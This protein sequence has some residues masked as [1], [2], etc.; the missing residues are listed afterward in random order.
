MKRRLIVH[1]P[2]ILMEQTF[3]TDDIQVLSY[4]EN[5]QNKTS[6]LSDFGDQDE[7]P[8]L[9]E[10][11]IHQQ[12]RTEDNVFQHVSDVGPLNSSSELQLASSSVYG[13]V[14][15]TAD[16]CLEHGISDPI[17]ILRYYQQKIVL[18]RKLDIED[19]SEV[20]EGETNFIL[21]D[22]NR[23]LESALE[24]IS[25]ITN[26]RTC[27]EV[28]F[29]GETSVDLGGPRKEFFVLAL[30]DMK[31]KYFNPVREWSVEYETLGKIMALS[32]LQNGKMPRVL[33]PELIQEIFQKE[34]CRP[35]MKDLRKGL[36]ALG[37]YSLALKLPGLI[38][39]FTPGSSTP[40]TVKKLSHL[41]HPN[42]SE[43]GSNR[44]KIESVVYSNFVKY[45]RE[46]ASGRR[47]NITLQSILQF[48]T[49]SDEEP[50]LGFAL[51]PSITFVINNNSFLPTAN[52]CI[53]KLNLYI[54]E[55]SEDIPSNDILFALYDYA[56][57]N[58]YFG[59]K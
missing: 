18:G 16:Y 12:A 24:E 43:E 54:A 19:D 17:E 50:I 28:Q 56:F 37:V 2:P 49:G 45:M 6:A 23:V 10:T 57:T 9:L 30:R 7:L 20:I 58:S 15:E 32:I 47:G 21:I 4:E 35:C 5:I 27:L 13:I 1:V 3:T 48:V 41:L 40:L 36:D 52:T 22:R 29:Y 53:N 39:V 34:E 59:L 25:G 26:L 31:E 42:F 38:N 46:V 51:D 55:K 33:R 11:Q 44:R 8:Q 14:D